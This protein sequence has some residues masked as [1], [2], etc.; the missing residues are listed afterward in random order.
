MLVDIQDVTPDNAQTLI[1]AGVETVSDLLD[2]DMEELLTINGLDEESLDLIYEAVQSFIEREIVADEEIIS[3]GG[4]LDSDDS[5]NNDKS[6]GAELDDISTS[7][8][9]L[10]DDSKDAPKM[11]DQA[12]VT[13]S[14]T[15]PD[16]PDSGEK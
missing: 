12:P 9:D 15:E 10:N 3:N 1:K 13:N 8:K 11:I 7:P 2:A 16:L 6:E 4:D 14:T 5:L